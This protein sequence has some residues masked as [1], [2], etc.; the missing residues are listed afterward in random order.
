MDVVILGSGSAGLAAAIYARR[1]EL[2]TLVLGDLPGGTIVQ[3]HLVENYPGFASLSG[4]ELMQNFLAHAQSLQ[5]EIRQARVTAVQ[6]TA[7]GFVVQAGQAQIGTKALI[8]ATGTIYRRLNIPGEKEFENKGVSFCATCDAPFYKGQRVAV[9]GGSDSAVKEG[10]L[11]A[12]HTRQVL[13]IYRRDQLRAEPINLRRL[14]QKANIKVI[15]NEE[16][17]EIFGDEKVTGVQ[18]KSGARLD[19]AG[20]FVEIGRLPRTELA[21]KLGVALNEQREIKIDRN[22]KTN[23]AGVFAAGDCTDSSFKQAL[24]AAAE[25]ARA[26]QAAFEFIT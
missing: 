23:L 1:F 17:T 7:E 25:G 3:T 21:A 12:E 20:V 2:E 16:V 19:L 15:C 18:L 22:S 5:T 26:A 9:I 10:L 6:A 14:E 11:L 4:S 8:F 24:T 13:I